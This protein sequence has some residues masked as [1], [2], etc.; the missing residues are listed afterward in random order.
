MDI[1][2]ALS[3]EESK[4]QRQLAAIQGAITALTGSAT[5]AVTPAHNSSARRGGKRILSAAGR[6]NII[7]ATKARWAK[8]RVEKAK[9]VK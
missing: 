2:G 8:I 5:T 3:E 9:K 1:I 6:A 4:L 7:R